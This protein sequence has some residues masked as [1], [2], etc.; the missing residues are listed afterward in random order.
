MERAASAIHKTWTNDRSGRAYRRWAVLICSVVLA[1]VAAACGG[2]ENGE[3]ASAGEGRL[4]ERLVSTIP[5]PRSGGQAP[6]T[7][8]ATTDG[9]TGAY[10]AVVA[11]GDEVV[12][13]VCDGETVG[14]PLAGSLSGG[15]FDLSDNGLRVNGT[16]QGDVVRGELTLPRS[17]PVAF[18]ARPAV[19]G[20]TGLYRAVTP[21]DGDQVVTWWVQTEQGI[22]GTRQDRTGQKGFATSDPSG[23][24]GAN[25]GDDRNRRR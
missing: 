14:E 19:E 21:V 16:L 5:A 18:T 6:G 9:S 17:G 20:T 24:E 12:A 4:P 2:E 7:Y 15:R 22:K 23:F 25:V 13:Y 11:Q 3:E 8:V 10:L 1:V